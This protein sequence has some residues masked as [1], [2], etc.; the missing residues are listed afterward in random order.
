MQKSPWGASL[1]KVT[2]TTYATARFFDIRPASVAEYHVNASGTE[3]LFRNT[4]YTYEESAELER[5]TTT[6]TAGGSSQQQVSI[7]ETFGAEPAYAYAAGKP[8]FSQDVAGVQTVHEYAATTEHD[9]IHK[10]TSITK[11]NGELVAAQSRKSESFIAANDTTTF[12]QECIWDGT[13]WLLLD[14]TAYEYDEQQRVVKTTR[15]NG[16]FSTTT[17][18]CCGRLS[19]TDEDGITTTYAYDSAR[20]LTEISREEV[21]DGET[22]ITPETITEFTRDAAGRVLTTI[23]RVG[24]METTEATEYDALGRVTKQTDV[25]GR[26]T[27]TEYSDDG[28]TTTVT[29]PAGATSITT[30]NVDGSTASVGG[31]AQRAL[32]YVYDLNGNSLRTTTKLEDG[33]TIAQ[34][35]VNGFGQTTVQAQASTSGFIYSRSEFNAKGQLVKQYQDTGWNTAKTAATL[36]EYDCFGNVSKQTLALADSP[37]KDNSPVVEM[38]Y[39]VE[40]AE[41]GV[42]SVTTQTRYNAAGEPLNAMQKQLISQL[43]ETLASKSI[44]TDER[45]NSAT[46]WSEFTAP[47]KMTNYSTIPTSE[48]VAEAVSVDGFTLSQK[49]YAGITTSASRSYT[50]TG[51]IL[52][53][54][55]GRGNATTSRTDLAGRTIS[56]TDSSGAVTTTLYDS[57]HDRPAVVTDADGNTS[58][59][60]YDHRSRKIAEWGTALQPA[61][62]GYDDM[63]N[64][65]TLRTFRAGTE[66]ISSNPSERTDGDVTTW[67]F[68]PA[69]GLELSKTYAD[70]TAVVKTYDAYNRL[71]TETDA[72]GNVKTHSYEHARGLHLGTTYTVVDGTAETSA[73]SFTY[74][75]LGQLTQLTDDSGV[76]TFTYNSYGER[77]IDSLVVDGDTHLVTELRDTFGRSTGYTYAK[78][79]SVLQTVSTSYGTDGRINSAGFLHGGAM[80]QFSYEYLQG[81]NLLHKLTKPNG[82]TLTLSYEAQRDLLTGMAYHRD[83]TLVVQREYTYDV[84]GRPSARTT[85]RQGNV[86]NDS[87]I[88]NSRSELASA[89]VNGESY[90]Y[91]YDNVGN[92]R[93]SME[94]GDYAFYEA[95]EL[96]QYTDIAGMEDEAEFD[97]TPVFDAEGNLTV[98]KTE[99][100]IWAAVY[101]A[102]NRPVSFTNEATGTVVTCAYDSM[103]RRSFK[104]VTVNGTVTLHQRYLYRGY[105]QIACIDLTRS[106]HPGLWL[107][108]WDPTQPVATLPM[109][110][111]KDGTW[112]TYGL[113]LTKN[114][115]EIFGSSGYISTTYTYSPYG[116]VT[117]SGTVTQPIQWSSEIADA[118]IGLIYFNYRYYNSYDGRWINRDTMYELGFLNLYR[119]SNDLYSVDTLGLFCDD[120]KNSH[121]T[122]SGIE[123]FTLTFKHV[124]LQDMDITIQD[125]SSTIRKK[126]NGYIKEKV[127]KGLEN[128]FPELK[129]LRQLTKSA[130][131]LYST[132]KSKL[133]FWVKLFSSVGTLYDKVEITLT[134]SLCCCSTLKKVKQKGNKKQKATPKDKYPKTKY[135][136]KA[137]QVKGYSSKKLFLDLRGAI[138]GGVVYPDKI[139]K[140]VINTTVNTVFNTLKSAV[141]KLK[142]NKCGN[143]TR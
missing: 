10:H 94:A 91:D 103:G 79:S 127:K 62:F 85:S 58:C 74:N 131:Q 46:E 2:R 4:T 93:M 87:F 129:E 111:Q 41:D 64:M 38:A 5:I 137:K 133:S 16:R 95:N 11:V 124:G 119:H 84:L 102:E 29:T 143:N 21:Y 3:V 13:Q 90:G 20:Q 101:N 70:G 140:H 125:P 8:K 104:K 22:C 43:S 76:R 7:E 63:D 68:H 28:L 44:S 40:A 54:V 33:T 96:N 71:S 35:I 57:A 88:H 51:M 49:D 67:A 32:V 86:V 100:G 72:R 12:E 66:I 136:C 15:G 56:V 97:F 108:T 42:F 81:T 99:T 112:Y 109:A 105:L 83:N 17:W 80:K 115:C 89:Q 48:I 59:Y 107:I 106:H 82:M 128:Q 26:V 113:D 121:N 50:A 1:A 141:I 45:G 98:I 75:H 110:I 135:C 30:R 53:H 6:V 73:R 142:A 27:T 78:N 24:P 134:S 39:S 47:S 132:M 19:E 9:A 118:N 120:K 52:V 61:C 77:E 123:S 114:V 126:L 25:L 139:G 37:T 60:K 18:M 69:T 138:I 116:A 34:S 55:D 14:T 36:Y 31:T 23:R 122:Y 130:M 117:T 92:R 65:T